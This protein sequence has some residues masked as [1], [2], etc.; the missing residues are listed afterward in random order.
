MSFVWDEVFL[1]RIAVIEIAILLERKSGIVFY[2]ATHQRRVVVDTPMVG[3]GLTYLLIVRIFCFLCKG[4][5]AYA[6]HEKQEK[7]L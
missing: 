1:K 2:I 4:H 5:S 7:Y 6:R 3:N